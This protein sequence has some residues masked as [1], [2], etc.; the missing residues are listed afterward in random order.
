MYNVIVNPET[1]KKVS[2]YS[3][4]G[5]HI[6]ETYISMIPNLSGG[7]RENIDKSDNVLDKAYI[8]I[9][10][11]VNFSK[12]DSHMIEILKNDLSKVTLPVLRSV[13]VYALDDY[14]NFKKTVQS[15]FNAIDVT[16]L[17]MVK[18]KLD[19]AANA[20]EASKIVQVILG[21]GV[22]VISAMN[23]AINSKITKLLKEGDTY[24][25]IKEDLSMLYNYF[26]DQGAHKRSWMVVTTQN[27]FGENHIVESLKY[28]FTA[29]LELASK[30]PTHDSK[31]DLIHIIDKVDEF[32][33][34][35]YEI[36]YKLLNAIF[37]LGF[38]G[39]DLIRLIQRSHYIYD[40]Y[41]LIYILGGMGNE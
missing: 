6:L 32:F 25:E 30:D 16:K 12:I 37:V 19:K 2:I 7:F 41:M 13:P 36:D 20:L 26:S 24:S 40:I 10:S 31:K 8:V 11:K 9:R 33:K 38:S 14:I 15:I 4:K 1:N 28:I 21:L 34:T 27:T 18:R 5:K 29:F 23:T 35:L 22:G 17:G 39:K 3:K